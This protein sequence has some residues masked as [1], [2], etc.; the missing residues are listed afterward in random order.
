MPL[1]KGGLVGARVEVSRG[2]RGVK[3]ISLQM[4]GKTQSLTCLLFL[5]TLIVPSVLLHYTSIAPLTGN[6][7][8]PSSRPRL[9]VMAAGGGAGAADPAPRG[10]TPA[11][12][13]AE[14]R[15]GMPGEIVQYRISHLIHKNFPAPDVEGVERL[16]KE[17]ANYVVSDKPDDA[18]EWV[19]YWLGCAYQYLCNA[20]HDL[21]PAFFCAAALGAI[22][23]LSLVFHRTILGRVRTPA[24]QVPEEGAAA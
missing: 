12:Q 19:A 8:K 4:K 14:P 6:V 9:P 18:V 20:A 7:P 16:I 15:P 22:T 2:G 21:Y 5:L 11:S 1:V 10:E 13:G 24:I 23:L 3:N 17:N